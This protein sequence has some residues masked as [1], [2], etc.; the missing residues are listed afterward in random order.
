M[1]GVANVRTAYAEAL[2]AAEQSRDD[3]A[4]RLVAYAALD[5]LHAAHRRETELQTAIERLRAAPHA[6]SAD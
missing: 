6:G 5:Q 3:A 2:I 4:W 1:N